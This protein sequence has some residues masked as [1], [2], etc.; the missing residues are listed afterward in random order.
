M[1]A[2]E[3]KEGVIFD[4]PDK[5]V[6]GYRVFTPG[7]HETK[8]FEA[9]VDMLIEY[10][11]NTIMIEV[12]GA[13]EYKKHPIINEEWV[14][15]CKEVNKSPYEAERIQRKTFKWSKNSIHTNNGGGGFISQEQMKTVVAYCKERG[16]EVIPEVPSLSHSDYIVRA[17]PELNERKEDT[18]PD[19]YCPSNPKS[20]EV[21]FDI[22]DEVIDVFEPEYINIGHDEGYTFAKCDK[23]KDKEPVDLF[24]GDI[25]K[26]NDYLQFIQ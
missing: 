7:Y 10:K 19:T 18:Y 2:G 1:K 3:L 20:Y 4:Y 5:P 12:G 21:L 8:D 22:L 16:L 9:M 23:C 26:I 11:Y 17:Y 24:V 15:Y 14:K 13:M 6:R 25:I